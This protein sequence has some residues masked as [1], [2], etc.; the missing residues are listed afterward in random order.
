[1][2]GEIVFTKETDRYIV[3]IHA[4]KLTEEQREAAWRKAIVEFYRAVEK[5][6]KSRGAWPNE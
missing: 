5:N 2:A 6:P 1:M 3:R 4:G